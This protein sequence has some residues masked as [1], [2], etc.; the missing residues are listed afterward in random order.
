MQDERRG[1]GGTSPRRPHTNGTN[2]F[3]PDGM[4]ARPVPFDELADG[5]IDLVAVQA[6]DELISAL[7]AGMSVSTPGVHGYDADDQVV[8]LLASWRS[9]V[10]SEPLPELVDLDTAMATVQAASRPAGRRARHLFPLA[11]AAAMIV[12]TIGGVSYGAADARPGDSLWEVSRVLYSERAESVEAAVRVESRID[13]AKD[14]LTRG[15]PAVA[16][17]VLAAAEE[18]LAAI[19]IEEG[20]VELSDTASFLEAKAAETPQGQR[21]Q[22]GTPLAADPQRRVPP[23][24]AAEGAPPAPATTTPGSSATSPTTSADPGVSPLDAGPT[25]ATVTPS[26]TPSPGGSVPPGDTQAPPPATTEGGADPTTTTGQGLG[27]TA[28]REGT[29]TASGSE[30]PTAS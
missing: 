4:R 1:F 26:P 7:A 6:D 22:P 13:Q 11:A 9:E 5:P 16:A 29:P 23:R 27:S 18:D 3:R 12:F 21:I 15:E 10:D 2:G 20:L 14:A 24:A 19:R 25:S 17:Q 28:T 30:T 8:A